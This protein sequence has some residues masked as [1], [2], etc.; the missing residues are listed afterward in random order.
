MDRKGYGRDAPM[1]ER[2]LNDSVPAFS[3]GTLVAAAVAP[4]EGRAF[5]ADE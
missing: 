4:G 3:S 2:E 5:R 1:R